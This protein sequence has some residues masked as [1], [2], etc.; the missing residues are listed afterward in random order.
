[1]QEFIDIIDSASRQVNEAREDQIEELRRLAGVDAA[2]TPR[3]RQEQQVKKVLKKAKH[4][5]LEPIKECVEMARKPKMR[6]VEQYL[7]DKCDEIIPKDD[8]KTPQGFVIKGNIYTADPSTRGGLIGNN[9]PEV[10]DPDDDQKI[11]PKDI[12]ETV[13]CK[14][15]FLKA[16]G[17][18]SDNPYE[19]TASPAKAKKFRGVLSG[20]IP[21]DMLARAMSGALGGGRERRTRWE[22]QMSRAP[23]GYENQQ[24]D[25]PGHEGEYDGGSEG[26]DMEMVA[27]DGPR[28]SMESRMSNYPP[29]EAQREGQRLNEGHMPR[30]QEHRSQ[31]DLTGL[32]AREAAGYRPRQPM[33]DALPRGDDEGTSHPSD[34]PRGAQPWDHNDRDPY[35]S[36]A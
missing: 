18:I 32:A 17:I 23:Q 4:K 10:L 13:L 35:G 14:R 6:T 33:T 31:M 11:N 25:V 21:A 22:D 7:C 20:Q 27:S 3:V 24:R 28:V 12:R 15:C 26:D 1:M 9:I 36:P 16:V 29:M 8:G 19:S 5:S 34:L 30:R 2:Q